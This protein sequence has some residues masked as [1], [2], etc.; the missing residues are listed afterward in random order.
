MG[1]KRS[2]GE[3]TGVKRGRG[4]CKEKQRRG[5]KICRKKEDKA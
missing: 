2:G 4:E 5:V 1:V 3:K